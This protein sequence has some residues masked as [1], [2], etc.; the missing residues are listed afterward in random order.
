MRCLPRL[1]GDLIII[2]ALGFIP[3]FMATALMIVLK[4]I[5]CHYGSGHK[6][7]IHFKYCHKSAEWKRKCVGGELIINKVWDGRDHEWWKGCKKGN[8][9][10]LESADGAEKVLHL[11]GHHDCR[12]SCYHRR[13]DRQN[14]AESD[15]HKLPL[16]FILSCDFEMQMQNVNAVHF[17]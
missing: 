12:S 15:R 3:M 7:I 10:T 5:M 16:M 6:R 4:V 11:L 14:L 17:A 2:I 9:S 1:P 8:T 13:T